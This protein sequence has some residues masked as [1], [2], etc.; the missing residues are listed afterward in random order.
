M[1]VSKARI[2]TSAA[3]I[4]LTIAC[5]MTGYG[6]YKMNHEEVFPAVAF[7]VGILGIMLSVLRNRKAQ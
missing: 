7:T 6:F 1:R 4:G 3:S 5:L 2:V